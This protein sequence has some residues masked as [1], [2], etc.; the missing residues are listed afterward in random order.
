MMLATA[1]Q[2]SSMPPWPSPMRADEYEPT[3]ADP[4]AAPSV[5]PGEERDVR[6]PSS[7]PEYGYSGPIYLAAFAGTAIAGGLFPIVLVVAA[8]IIAGPPREFLLQSVIVV[9]AGGLFGM[10]LAAAVALCVFPVVGAIQWLAGLYPWRVAMASIAGGWT[11]FVATQ[12]TVARELVDDTYQLVGLILTWIAMAMGHVFAGWAATRQKRLM[13]Y[14]LRRPEPEAQPRF[15][16]KQMLGLTTG[17]AVVAATISALQLRS[18]VHVALLS[19]MG[20]EAIGLTA[21]RLLGRRNP[22]P[23]GPGNQHTPVTRWAGTANVETEE[24]APEAAHPRSHER[25]T[26]DT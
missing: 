5:N 15:T 26:S 18:D 11:G 19:S 4:L 6:T 23:A 16:L 21:W 2:K 14:A 12:A 17:L 8:L 22:P 24:L 20:L 13:S 25:T 1:L 9:F 3:F 7:P 10:V